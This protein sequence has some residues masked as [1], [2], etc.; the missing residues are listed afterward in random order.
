MNRKNLNAFLAAGLSS[1]MSLGIAAPPGTGQTP[2]SKPSAVHHSSAGSLE[3]WWK[4]AVIYEIYPRSFQDSNGDGIGDLNGITAHLDY[5]QKLGVDAIWITPCYPSPQVDFGYDISDYEA[6]DP[7]YGTMADFDRLVAEA[8]KHNIRVVMDMVMNHSSDKHKWFLESRSSRDNPKRNWYVW[9]DGKGETATDKGQPPNNWQSDFGHSAWEWD[10]KTRQ[11]YYHKFYIQ[12]PDFNWNNPAVEKAFDDILNFWMKKGVAGFR[13]DAI[14]TLFED[15][16]WRD[17]KELKDK[18]GKT[19]LNAYGDVA[20]DDAMTNN[21]PQ[22]YDVLQHVRKVE[23]SVNPNTFPGRRVMIGET[24]VPTVKDLLNMYGTKE[25]PEFELPMDTQLGFINKLN[26]AT[27][28]S[29]LDDVETK[30]E[31]NEPLLVFDNHDNPRID[32]RYGDGVHDT[33]ITRVISTILFASRGTSLFYYGAELGMK[34][35][36]PTRKDDVKDPVGLTGWPKDKGRD[37]ERTPMQWDDSVNAGFSKAKPWLPVP[38]NKAE[39]N[40][41]AEESDPNS[42][43]NWYEA[44]IKL[45]KT[46]PAFLSGENVMLNTDDPKVL[47]WLR[48]GSDHSAVVVATNFTAE[49]QTVNLSAASA[50]VSG[51]KV[52]TLLKTPGAADPISIDKVELPAFG[53][54]IGE[55]Q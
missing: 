20:L 46:N 7:Q 37:G 26:V 34:T 29:K 16:Q 51:T 47:S 40:V 27:F 54:Y 25:K 44:L 18:E 8:K 48:R 14:T 33:D 32:A 50:G 35:T 1:A 4:N 21:L 6:I 53:V 43:L 55:V 38:P 9:R 5:L 2:D 41:K 31:G 11:Y 49:P 36:P 17:D 28:R 52:K 22:V 24:Y 30:I 23:D 3:N 42:L 45:K 12:Q 39:I 19:Y 13:F 15:P 10:E